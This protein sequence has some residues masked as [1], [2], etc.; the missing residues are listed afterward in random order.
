MTSGSTKAQWTPTATSMP[1]H[2]E[3]V[4]VARGTYVFVSR[5]INGWGRN[6][7]KVYWDGYSS[8]GLDHFDHWMPLPPPPAQPKRRDLRKTV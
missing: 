7:S 4:L 6:S 3:Y 5:V 1:P 2:Y 8:A